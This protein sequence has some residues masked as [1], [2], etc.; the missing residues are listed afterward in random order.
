MIFISL[1]EEDESCHKLLKY[2]LDLGSSLKVL[3]IDVKTH[4]HLIDTD[5]KK[6][7]AEDVNK[8]RTLAKDEAT[9]LASEALK[10][11]FFN[12][13]QTIIDSSH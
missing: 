1:Q 2:F 3:C 7:M 6:L 11:I 10:I 8:N 4:S 12:P 13:N 9:S 5:E